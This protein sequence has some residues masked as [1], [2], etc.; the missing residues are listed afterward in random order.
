MGRA[1]FGGTGRAMPR[2]VKLEIRDRL[3]AGETWVHVAAAIGICQGTI[4]RVLNEAGGMPPRWSARSSSQLTC[5]QREDISL[6]LAAGKSYA[7]LGREIGCHRSTIK[8]EV[9]RQLDRHENPYGRDGYRAWRADRDAYRRARR[10]KDSKL[11]T[12]RRLHDVVEA[13][14]VKHWSPRQI[15]IRLVIDFPD[16][17]EMRV[18]HETIYQSLFVQ[19]KGGFRDDLVKCLR[20]G[21]TR[22]R[23]QSR[24]TRAGSIK[25]MVMISDRPAE[26]EDRAVPGHW[27]GDLILG[28]NNRSAIVTLV[29]RS[30]RFLMMIALPDDHKAETVAAAIA[31]HITTLPAQLRRS[32]TW[33]QG[34]EMAEHVKFTIA[35][36]IAVYFCDPHSPWQRGTNENTNGL[37]RQYFPK[38]TDLSVHPQSELDRVADELNGR[39]RET[40]GGMTPSEKFAELV[41]LTV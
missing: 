27:E 7:Q 28:R 40:L 30:T 24:M 22:R 12:N 1:R 36:D 31:K 33:D 35:T 32:I 8:R 11:T 6:G 34:S 5:A 16:D 3:L 10:A 2:E 19:A 39:P 18:S 23:T 15:S 25:D 4:A 41:A 38:G 13:G 20:T 29:E 21:R 17:L 14:L 37:I 26:I 9:D